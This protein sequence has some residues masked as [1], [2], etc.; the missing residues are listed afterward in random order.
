MNQ[1]AAIVVTVTGRGALT[2][3]PEERADA[4]L[5]GVRSLRWWT[6]PESCWFPTLREQAGGLQ[7]T[8]AAVPTA[9]REGPASAR[10]GMVGGGQLA[11]MTHQAAVDLGVC[12][13]VLVPSPTEPAVVA[14]AHHLCGAHDSLEMLRTLAERCEVVTLDHEHVPAEHLHAL[15]AAGHALRPRAE[16]VGL[17]QDKLLARR[18]LEHAGFPVPPYAP[19][20]LGALDVVAGFAERWGWPVV[21]KSRRGGYDG[22][23]VHVLDDLAAA[24][25][26]LGTDTSGGWLV[27]ANVA[28]ATE[29]AVLVAR[30][31]SGY[32][33]V[34]PVVETC[35]VDGMCRELVMPARIPDAVAAAAARLAESIA[36]GI[37]N[38]GVLAVELFLTTEGDLVVNELASRPHN[39]GHATIEATATS[40]FHNHLRGVLDWPLG[41]TAMVAPAA[42][43]VNVIGS[44]SASDPLQHLAAA[45][46]VSGANVHLYAK[47]PRPGRKL[48]HVTA[49]GADHDEAL[50]TARA[51]A[52]LLTGE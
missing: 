39:S 14:G 31:P 32:T 51:A 5:A 4:V 24:Q 28:I 6:D 16:A 19:V 50:D 25:G 38:T 1:A 37:D 29:L 41:S 34:Y 33:A 17:A 23:G 44:S 49:L 7:V 47:A 26:V 11:R 30:N 15:Q 3:V 45:L 46:S 35:Q 20:D 48:G 40:Q 52:R 8:P 21:A 2:V 9:S 42:A 18:T 13:E 22:R 43:T 12:L 27:E 36:D 10:V